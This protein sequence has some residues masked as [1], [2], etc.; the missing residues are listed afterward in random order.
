ML[1]LKG[2]PPYPPLSGGYEEPKPLVGGK[3]NQNPA[4]PVEGLPFFTP[5]T[6]GGRG[7]CS[8]E[9]GFFNIPLE[10]EWLLGDPQRGNVFFL[11]RGSIRRV[12]KPGISRQPHRFVIIHLIKRPRTSCPPV[13]A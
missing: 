13:M 11:P 7:G 3:K 12:T 8:F 5:L 9:E 2:N 6:R 10:G 4:P 1:P